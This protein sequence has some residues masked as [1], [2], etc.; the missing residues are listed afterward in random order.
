MLFMFFK[1]FKN[2]QTIKISI[3]TNFYAANTPFFKFWI[4]PYDLI[5]W[6]GWVP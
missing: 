3:E 2:V 1:Q 4:V 6:Q 5:P